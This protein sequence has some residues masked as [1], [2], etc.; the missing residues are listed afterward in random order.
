MS[1][2]FRSFLLFTC[3]ALVIPLAT[4]NELVVFDAW[5]R[6]L[7]AG[8]PAAGY[9]Q[10]RNDGQ[11]D[12]DLIDV[13]SP[14]FG[15]VMLHRTLDEDGHVRMVPVEKLAVAAGTTLSF[16]PGGYHLMLMNPRYR[17]AVGSDV[18][19]TFIFSDGEKIDTRFKVRGPGGH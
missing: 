5:I 16:G 12:V 1:W 10:V 7:P 19:M 2:F 15:E 13:K 3:F 17:L 4:A 8:A 11:A 9:F 18:P 14:A 6:L